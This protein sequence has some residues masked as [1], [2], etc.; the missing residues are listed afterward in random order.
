M[1]LC[2]GDAA[3]LLTT[4]FLA[5]C[6]P[7]A[8]VAPL[9]L[10]TPQEPSL[11]IGRALLAP[12]DDD[13]FYVA[14]GDSI[15]RLRVRARDGSGLP[16][17]GISVDF[18]TDDGLSRT[19][20]GS[21]VTDSAGIAFVPPFVAS[22]VIGRHNLL[23]SSPGLDPTAYAYLVLP[24]SYGGP[25]QRR[26]PIPT[27][28][29]P[30]YPQLTGTLA[31]LDGRDSLRVVT[32]GSSSTWG[33][34]SSNP[35]ATYPARLQARLR[36]AYTGSV[37]TVSNKGVGGQ[38]A[39]EMVARFGTDVYPARPHLVIWQ[40][41]T[42][43]AR[44][45]TPIA[46]FRATLRAGIGQ[47]RARGLDVLLL[48]SQAYPAQPA[49]YEAYQQALAEVAT[50]LD[51]PLVNRYRLMRAYVASGRYAYADL[52]WSADNF[53]P[54]DLTYDCMAHWILAGVMAAQVGGA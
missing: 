17:T 20:L 14:A 7:D 5:A 26:C 18:A 49:N 43:E 1:R 34:G 33:T 27:S 13:R 24:A 2:R 45:G 48:D 35:S 41:G 40:T 32:I 46:E 8:P 10:E 9:H 39:T 4:V 3:A 31:A 28:L 52:L 25:S 12:V 47:L 36:E 11:P 38:L 30:R 6:G 21:G 16:F 22:A 54:N 23:A 15:R 53:H 37:V 44:A 19:P 51:V 29:L 42:I 50:E